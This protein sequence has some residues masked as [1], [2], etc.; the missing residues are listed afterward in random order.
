MNVRKIS[1]K[2]EKSV[3]K[4]MKANVVVASGALW[5]M[6]FIKNFLIEC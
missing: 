2:Q 4:D 5:G 1:Q 6:N 3:A